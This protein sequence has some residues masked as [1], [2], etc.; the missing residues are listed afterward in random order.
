MST[1][2]HVFLSPR[3][4]ARGTS[5]TMPEVSFQKYSV[6]QH[7][8][9][10]IQSTSQS[11]TSAEQTTAWWQLPMLRTRGPP[12]LRAC[13][14]DAHFITPGTLALSTPLRCPSCCPTLLDHPPTCH[15]ESESTEDFCVQFVTRCGHCLCLFLVSLP[16]LSF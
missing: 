16:R 5:A 6:R 4:P 10:P 3:G 12:R 15:S 13:S 14:L 7:P 1:A 11:T 2:S 8:L 9:T